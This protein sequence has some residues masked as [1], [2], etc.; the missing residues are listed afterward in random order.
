MLSEKGECEIDQ[1]EV[2]A[3]MKVIFEGLTRN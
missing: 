2:N 3:E 1:E